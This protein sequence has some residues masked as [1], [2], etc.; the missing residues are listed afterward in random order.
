VIRDIGAV[1]DHIRA[2]NRISRVTLIGWSWGAMTA[3]YYASLHSEKVGKLVL[4]AP[5]Y[6]NPLH[7]NLGAGSGLQDKRNPSQFNPA[8]GAYRLGTG[9]A[10]NKRWDGEIPV[11]NKDDYREPGVQEAFNQA[12]LAT[13]PTS[14][15][16]NPPALRAPN[17]VLEDS[18][19]QAT[20]RRLWNAA[21]IYVPTLVIAGEDDTWSFPHDREGLMRDLTN[22]PAKKQVTI[23]HATHFVLFEKQRFKFFEEIES[24]LKSGASATR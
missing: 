10:N 22:A 13:D 1:V 14:G 8:M 3:G 6:D 2:K 7:T 15:T 20:G 24:F 18:F 16:R 21:N 23:P 12:A 5:L 17:G 9:E 19:Y 11:P 4:Y